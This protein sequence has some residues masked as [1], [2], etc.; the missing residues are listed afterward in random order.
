MRNIFILF[1]SLLLLSPAFAVEKLGPKATHAA[2]MSGDMVLID[3]RRPDE[4][5]ATGVAQGA[6][7]IDMRAADFAARIKA[8]RASNP[9]RK[10]GLIC[11]VGVRSA[12][13]S[14]RLEQAGLTGLVDVI[15]GTALWIDQGLPLA[16]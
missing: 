5:Q 1:F 9:G 3:I 7:K 12:R 13:L 14:N 4:W 11:Q 10:I 2:V 16:R 6:L 8:I 15:G